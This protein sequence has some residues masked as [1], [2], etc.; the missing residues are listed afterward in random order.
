MSVTNE[1]RAACARVAEAAR[2]VRIDAAR[3]EEYALS[4]PLERAVAPSVDWSRHYRGAEDAETAA[5]CSSA[6]RYVSTMDA[7]ADGR[8][9]LAGP[10]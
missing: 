2:W 5:N 6:D 7:G 1:I 9:K 8:C 3:I 4:L 10:V